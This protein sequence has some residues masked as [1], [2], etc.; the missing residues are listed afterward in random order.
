MSNRSTA[1][2]T[3]ATTKPRMGGRAMLIAL[4]VLGEQT[5][6]ALGRAI[7]G[8][9]SAAKVA[10]RAMTIAAGAMGISLTGR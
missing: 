9:K 4:E 6:I 2:K 10:E 3:N 1:A 8:N 5:D 7:K